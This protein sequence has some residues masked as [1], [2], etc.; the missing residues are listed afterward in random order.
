MIKKI[1]DS[2][3]SGIQV[4]LKQLSMSI[5]IDGNCCNFLLEVHDQERLFALTRSGSMLML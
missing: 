5:R 4:A 3:L 1:P 2:P